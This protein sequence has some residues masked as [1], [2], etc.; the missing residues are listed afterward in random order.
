MGLWVEEELGLTPPPRPSDV[1]DLSLPHSE[2]VSFKRPV[3]GFSGGA[4]CPF[5]VGIPKEA[6]GGT[7]LGQSLL[8]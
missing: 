1:E 7:L 4:A 2:K 8:N 6:V 3:V 5:Q